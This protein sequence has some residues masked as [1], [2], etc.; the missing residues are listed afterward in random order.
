MYQCKLPST[1]SIPNI[2]DQQPAQ[3][4]IFIINHLSLEYN[5]Q[6]AFKLKNDCPLIDA[7]SLQL[8]TRVQDVIC[9]HVKSNC[10]FVIERN[11]KII[12]EPAPTY[13]S[14]YNCQS[15][16]NVFLISSITVNRT[17][18]P[19]IR[20]QPHVPIPHRRSITQYFKHLNNLYEPN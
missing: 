9:V 7:S 16:R 17:S 15:F 13:R 3:A 4:K 2:I 19:D 6:F 5:K 8:M 11:L 18:V 14:Y 10:L 12:K 1:N 20:C